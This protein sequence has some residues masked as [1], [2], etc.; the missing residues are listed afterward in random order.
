ME[1]T[2]NNPAATASHTSTPPPVFDESL[3][4]VLNASVEQNRWL[5]SNVTTLLTMVDHMAPQLSKLTSRLGAVEETLRIGAPDSLASTPFS[6]AAPVFSG[7]AAFPSTPAGRHPGFSRNAPPLGGAAVPVH[8]VDGSYDLVPILSPIGGATPYEFPFKLRLNSLQDDGVEAARLF[9][10]RVHAFL[11]RHRALPYDLASAFVDQ[12]WLQ[13]LMHAATDTP[14]S[15][16]DSCE[17]MNALWS[18][19][20][21]TDAGQHPST[22]IK[23]IAPFSP[24]RRGQPYQAMQ[25]ALSAARLQ[26]EVSEA[27]RFYTTDELQSAQVA[28]AVKRSVIALLPPDIAA[29]FRERFSADPAVT[30][31]DVLEAFVGLTRNPVQGVAASWLPEETLR[32]AFTP[33][34]APPLPPEAPPQQSRQQQQQQFHQSEQP[35]QQRQQLRPAGGAPTPPHPNA[36]SAPLPNPH[37][38]KQLSHPS[39][40][41]NSIPRGP[42]PN[43]GCNSTRHGSTSSVCH[44]NAECVVDPWT[45]RGARAAAAHSGGGAF[46][47][48]RTPPQP[49]STS[50]SSREAALAAP[51]SAN[52]RRQSQQQPQQGSSSTTL[53]QPSSAAPSSSAA[54]L[55]L[56]SSLWAT[57][58]SSS[59]AIQA[60]L[61]TATLGDHHHDHHQHSDTDSVL[62]HAS[63]GSTDRRAIHSSILHGILDDDDAEH[64][65]RGYECNWCG[66]CDACVR[67]QQQQGQHL[68]P[69]QL[70]DAHYYYRSQRGTPD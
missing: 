61:S 53:S 28:R 9:V 35:Q 22:R 43:D 12:E 31:G 26:A 45:Q 14:V 24:G 55:S 67:E 36:A 34:L 57:G 13:I 38:Q 52:T 40:S 62:S 20:H 10:R 69:H 23:E 48:L 46:S 6:A 59:P 5:V 3:A 4:R 33:P 21:D 7:A 49:P 18:L 50:T 60:S 11:A 54:P 27:L 16:P 17:I 25:T 70:E 63:A 44:T 58:S 56:P 1:L 47:N 37:A 64:H 39:R 42:G 41:S 51:S 15:N 19:V 2:S 68:Q 29:V 65:Q 66:S 30:Y 32:K 8:V